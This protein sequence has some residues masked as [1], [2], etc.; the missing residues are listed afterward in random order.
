MSD[1]LASSAPDDRR[2]AVAAAAE[3]HSARVRLLRRALP[4]TIVILVALLIAWPFFD[5]GRGV[6]S[7]LPEDFQVETDFALSPDTGTLQMTRSRFTGI[8]GNGRPFLVTADQVWEADGQE[9]F[10][11]VD[12]MADLQLDDTA[13]VALRAQAG[14]YVEAEDR[15]HVAGDVVILIDRGYR[16]LTD[17]LTVSLAE[18]SLSGDRP[19]Q[20]I[21]RDATIAAQGLSITGNGDQ[22]RFEG[23]AT[24]TLTPGA[25]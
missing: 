6:L 23:P 10:V 2:A 7:E 11:L 8:D 9:G 19:V 14:R 13:W 17:A 16:L 20:V 18:A 1:R 21:G 25:G 5:R 12:P 15:L 22:I 4:A 24:L 3:R